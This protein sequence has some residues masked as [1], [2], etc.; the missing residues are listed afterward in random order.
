MWGSSKE[1][2]RQDTVLRTQLVR[3]LY[4]TICLVRVLYIFYL[5]PALHIHTHKQPVTIV[6]MVTDIIT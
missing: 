2:R 5:T 4:T 6:A 1:P 3:R